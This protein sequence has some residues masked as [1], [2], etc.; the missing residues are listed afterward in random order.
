MFHLCTLGPPFLLN[1]VCDHTVILVMGVVAVRTPQHR[2]WDL[3]DLCGVT[4]VII[5]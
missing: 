3:T 5:I 2:G 1:R 4:G